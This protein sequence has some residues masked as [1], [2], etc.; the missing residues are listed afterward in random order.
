MD[1]NSYR[2]ETKEFLIR[3]GAINEGIDKKIELFE[4]EF[5]TR[6]IIPS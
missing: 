1:L 2:D 3:I 5:E 4:E 6:N